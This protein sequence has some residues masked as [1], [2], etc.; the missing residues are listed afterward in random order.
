M[1]QRT[2]YVIVPGD[3]ETRTGGYG[4]DR[5]VIAGLRARGWQVTVV[6][7]AGGYPWPTD[8]EREAAARALS[9]LPDAARVM[10]DGLAFG[11]LPTEAA[12]ECHRLRLVALV[13]HPLGLETGISPDE[14]RRLLAS[15]STA[16]SSARGVVVTSPRTV[17][18]VRALGVPHDL[19]AV[20]EPGTHRAA[21]APGSGSQTLQLLCVASITPRKGF[22]TLVTALTRLVHQAWHLTCVGSLERDAAYAQSVVALCSAPE[23]RGR[24][25]FAGELAGHSLEAAYQAADVFVLP[26]HY[27]GYGMVIA[28]ALARG[29]PVVSTPTGAIVELV[30]DSAGV[31]VP[32]GEPGLLAD[33]LDTLMT[34]PT[35]LASLRRGAVERRATIPTWEAA[36]DAMERALLRFTPP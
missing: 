31:L 30:G 17:S 24:V 21:A 1:D 33:A 6:G 28:E 35:R 9:E 36:A 2:L 20:V 8:S 32:P 15:E 11:A 10:V 14:S 5:A 12:H 18:A 26:T 19:I 22:D 16:L 4:Y 23:L 7:I 3:I 29:I 34:D 27:E 25:T 13:H